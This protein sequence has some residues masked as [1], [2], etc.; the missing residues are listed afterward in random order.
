MLVRYRGTG[1]QTVVVKGQAAGKSQ[2]FALE[3]DFYADSRHD[4]LPVLWAH[5]KVAFL[6]EQ[7][8]VNG[9][10]KELVNEVVRLG[11]A[12]GIATPYTSFLI[13]EDAGDQQAA[14]RAI[15][16]QRTAFEQADSGIEAVGWG[17][18]LALANECSSLAV[19][20]SCVPKAWQP[21]IPRK[22]GRHLMLHNSGHSHERI[23]KLGRIKLRSVVLAVLSPAPV[24]ARVAE[25]ADALG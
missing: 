19:G 3:V 25:L 23:R 20:Y 17:S 15:H 9:E 13:L 18:S 21:G 4:F 7:I 24:H 5:R 2:T 22:Y 11:R 10:T 8:R 1:R 6:L 14:T 12:F 16:Q